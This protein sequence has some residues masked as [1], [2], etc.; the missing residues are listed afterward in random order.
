MAQ[1][2][3]NLPR[4]NVY[5]KLMREGEAGQQEVWKGRLRNTSFARICKR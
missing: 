2:L 3:I 5:A 4:F 1:R